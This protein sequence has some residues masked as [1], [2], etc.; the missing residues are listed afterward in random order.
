MHMGH[1]GANPNWAGRDKYTYGYV[2]IFILLGHVQKYKQ[3]SYIQ[4]SYTETL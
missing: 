3:L 4:L 1:Y 2:P